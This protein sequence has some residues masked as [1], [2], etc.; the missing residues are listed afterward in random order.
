MCREQ[1]NTEAYECIELGQ[2]ELVPFQ[3]RT[4]KSPTLED[5]IQLYRQIPTEIGQIGQNI[6]RSQRSQRSPPLLWNR[7]F[8]SMSRCRAIWK[9]PLPSRVF[10]IFCN[11][12][13]APTPGRKKKETIERKQANSYDSSSFRNRVARPT[14]PRR[15]AVV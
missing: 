11:G 7:R 8:A 13:T 4:P 6:Q 10:S 9:H 1:K 15:I 5:S 2:V 12:N 3:S 14:S